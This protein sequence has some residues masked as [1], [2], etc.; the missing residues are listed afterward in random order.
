MRAQCLTHHFTSFVLI[1][2]GEKKIWMKN[3]LIFLDSSANLT[4]IPKIS[5]SSSAKNMHSGLVT[6]LFFLVLLSNTVFLGFYSLYNIYRYIYTYTYNILEFILEMKIDI[7]QKECPRSET[8]SMTEQANHTLNLK[9]KS[10]SNCIQ[11]KFSSRGNPRS[12]FHRIRNY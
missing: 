5:T 2:K 10:F 3:L 8:R 6:L 1:F 4:L 11:C 7:M 12:S 9:Y